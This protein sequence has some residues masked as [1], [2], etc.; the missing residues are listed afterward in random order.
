MYFLKY[1][2]IL[3]KLILFYHYLLDNSQD[4]MTSYSNPS[5]DSEL[6]KIYKNYAFKF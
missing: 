4:I 1:Y 2:H 5:F 6:N 3:P